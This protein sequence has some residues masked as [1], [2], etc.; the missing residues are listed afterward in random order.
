[1]QEK[2]CGGRRSREGAVER[3]RGRQS[4]EGAGEVVRVRE[5]S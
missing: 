1:M 3:V 2:L 5:K 4:L